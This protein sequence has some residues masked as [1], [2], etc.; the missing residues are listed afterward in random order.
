MN[1]ILYNTLKNPIIAILCDS[2]NDLASSTVDKFFAA[3]PDFF[4]TQFT[5]SSA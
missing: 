4:I 5:I 3:G 1:N 2:I